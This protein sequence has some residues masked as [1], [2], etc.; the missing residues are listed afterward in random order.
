MKVTLIRVLGK[1]FIKSDY[2]RDFISE[3]KKTVPSKNRRWNSAFP[4]SFF[5]RLMT[6]LPK[7]KLLNEE[8]IVKNIKSLCDRGVLQKSW[9][10]DDVY[11]EHIRDMC[12]KHFLEVYLS[13]DGNTI[14]IIAS[15]RVDYEEINI[16]QDKLLIKA[17]QYRPGKIVNFSWDIDTVN[18]VDNKRDE[19]N[20][21]FYSLSEDRW[22]YATNFSHGPKEEITSFISSNTMK[23]KVKYTKFVYEYSWEGTFSCP[24]NTLF[25][26]KGLFFLV[27]GENEVKLLGDNLEGW[28]KAQQIIEY[29]KILQ[30]LPEIKTDRKNIQNLLDGRPFEIVDIESA[31]K[32]CWPEKSLEIIE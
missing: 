24:E 27:I 25:K 11:F 6:S 9:E 26:L 5:Y 1:I 7:E 12:L 29:Q 23:F 8:Y 4:M 20:F 18:P 31:L 15:D 3:L 30:R 22:I 32:P 16:S 28:S 19:L 13:E 17:L 2:N 21:Q 14:R 10:V